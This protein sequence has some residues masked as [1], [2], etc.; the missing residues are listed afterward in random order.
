[1]EITFFGHACF[2]LKGKSGVLVVDPFAENM[3]KLP[4]D[5]SADIVAVTHQHPD[6]NYIKPFA[7]AFV[8]DGPGEY[9]VKGIS[10]VGVASFHDDKGGAERGNNTI[11]VFEIDSLR[12][13]HLGDLGHKLTQ[14][15]LAEMGP[16]DVVMVPVGGKYTIDPKTASEVVKQI[17]PWIVIPMHYKQI[18]PD[19]AGVEDFLKEMGKPDIQP[20]PKLIVAA[21]R[22]PTELQVV[23]L[24]RK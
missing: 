2:R 14:E 16:V 20:V 1:M 22:L 8:V 15:Q 9:E 4:K 24:E 18:N 10:V 5:V 3:G 19:L 21:D 23:V 13:A 6:H 7:G 17:D 11:Y 12:L